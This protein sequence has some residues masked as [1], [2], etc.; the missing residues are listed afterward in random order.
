M[1]QP[2]R[3][4]SP[5]ISIVCALA[6]FAVSSRLRDT[7]PEQGREAGGIFIFCR[8]PI[9]NGGRLRERISLLPFCWLPGT[10]RCAAPC[11]GVL[12]KRQS[13]RLANAL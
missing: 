1:L 4:Q 3:Q 7:Q 9:P 8:A 2:L 5:S 11:S 12:G 13:G 10:V 6:G